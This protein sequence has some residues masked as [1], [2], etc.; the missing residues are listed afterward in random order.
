MLIIPGFDFPYPIIDG[1]LEWA[2]Q[3]GAV[4][5]ALFITAERI[6]EPVS[7][8]STDL[9]E[10]GSPTKSSHQLIFDQLQ[11]LRSRA[12][13]MGV[14]FEGEIKANPSLNTVIELCAGASAVFV[15]RE[16]DNQEFMLEGLRFSKDELLSRLDELAA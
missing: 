13:S 5:K 9:P 3:S 11:F 4:L 10:A 1:A 2:K 8:V 15:N 14:A 7:G 16:G 6:R 12:E